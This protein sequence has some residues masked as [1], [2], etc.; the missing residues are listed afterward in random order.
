MVKDRVRAE[1]L[2]DIYPRFKNHIQADYLK[3][4]IMSIFQKRENNI[5]LRFNMAT[6]FDTNNFT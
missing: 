6:F 3:G 1:D 4:N 5:C 2:K